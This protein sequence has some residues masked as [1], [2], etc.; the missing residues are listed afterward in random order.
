MLGLIAAPSTVA[1][2]PSRVEMVRVVGRVVKVDPV[3]DVRAVNVPG[4]SMRDTRRRFVG[5]VTR[6]VDCRCRHRCRVILLIIAYQ[7]A[8]DAERHHHDPGT[9]H[10]LQ[11][12]GPPSVPPKHLAGNPASFTSPARR[13]LVVA[14]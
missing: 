10:P 13:C 14:A 9:H 8:N 2:E 11:Y 5:R 1:G 4:V 6:Q 3:A 7:R 12:P